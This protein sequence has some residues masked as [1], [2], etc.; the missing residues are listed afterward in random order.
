MEEWR[1]DGSKV[2]LNSLTSKKQNHGCTHFI[3]DSAETIIVA[4]GYDGSNYLQ[5]VEKMKRS[6]T[7]GPWSL[8]MNIGNLPQK[9][10]NFPMISWN[11][12]LVYILGGYLTSGTTDSIISSEDCITWKSENIT[13]PTGRYYHSAT[14]TEKLCQYMKLYYLLYTKIYHWF[15]FLMQ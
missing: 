12:G 3:R 6:S 7:G 9:R 4:G 13:I 11:N 8:W 15:N 1:L 5:S 10:L 2:G 14:S